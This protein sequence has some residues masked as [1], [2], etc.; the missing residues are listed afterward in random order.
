[1][2]DIVDPF[3][4]NVENKLVLIFAEDHYADQKGNKADDKAEQVCL[5]LGRNAVHQNT[6]HE[7]DHVIEGI[8]LI[9]RHK[10]IG[11]D[12]VGIENG[13]EIHQKH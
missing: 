9:N 7:S 4:S 13:G 5:W 1:M 2:I 10:M 3:K 12:G 6:A 11:N 8:E